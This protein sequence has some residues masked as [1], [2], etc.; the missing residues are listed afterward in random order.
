MTQYVVCPIANDAEKSD[1]TYTAAGDNFKLRLQE[2][3]RWTEDNL[4]EGPVT[5]AFGAGTDREHA[6]G[7]TLATLCAQVLLEW[8]PDADCVVNDNE[9]C[10]YGTYE[11]IEWIVRT[12]AST[13]RPEATQFVFF[14]Q[15]EHMLRVRLI[16]RMFFAATWGEAV[17]IET[18]HAPGHAL[19]RVHEMVKCGQVSLFFVRS[20]L[21]PAWQRVFPVRPRFEESY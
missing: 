12:V 7:P 19:S 4:P 13:H 15:P 11:E 10:F 18:S 14:T 2:A 3:V 20:T 8:Y 5:W 17:F 9:R 16:W 21:P 6:A 1:A